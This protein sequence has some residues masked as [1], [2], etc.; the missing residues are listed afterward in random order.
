M[1][2]QSLASRLGHADDARLLIINCDD[3]GSSHSA[4]IAT[5]RAM[6]YGVATSA[7]LMIP[8]PWAREA[9]TLFKGKAVGVHLTITSELEGYRW[10]GLTGG[11]SLYD[12]E[13]FLIADRLTAMQ[14]VDKEEA[15]AECHAQIETALRW[16]VDVTHLD[17]HMYAMHGRPDLFDVLLDLAEEFGLPIRMFSLAIEKK[18]GFP[19]RDITDKRGVLYNDHLVS[20]WPR[21]TRDVFA[22]AVANLEPGVTEIYAHPVLEG[23]ELRA[24][25]PMHADIRASDS[26]FLVDPIARRSLEEHNVKTISFRD[27]RDLQRAQ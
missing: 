23:E 12:E 26:L 11:K 16:G 18:F 27:L 13:G 8:C 3:L 14:R 19:A 6:T 5:F 9:A 21:T 4:N 7:T 24:F 25:D 22:G 2:S 17:T 1:A 15:R 20:S 10:R